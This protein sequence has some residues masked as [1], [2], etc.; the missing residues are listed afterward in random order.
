MHTSCWRD[1][2]AHLSL[3]VVRGK[4]KDGE[5]RRGRGGGGKA[6]LSLQVV[7][8]KWKNGEGWWGGGGGEQGTCKS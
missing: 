8:G 6:H 5:G 2:T 1:G 3:Q 7:R 4:W